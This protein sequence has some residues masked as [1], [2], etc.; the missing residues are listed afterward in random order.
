MSG[1]A[2]STLIS[3]LKDEILDALSS[4]VSPFPLDF[5]IE[6][7]QDSGEEG[8]VLVPPPT[9]TDDFEICK[10]PS[11]RQVLLQSQSGGFEILDPQKPV[12]DCGISGWEVLF[13]QFNNPE[14][15][16]PLPITYFLP[17]IDDDEDDAPPPSVQE[18]D[19]DVPEISGKRKG[20]RKADSIDS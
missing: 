2:P 7:D 18:M 10:L 1:V 13:L 20:K 9:S 6:E 17:S 12:R 16:E 11:K 4:D 3:E 5:T 14:T 19:E 15:H 8:A